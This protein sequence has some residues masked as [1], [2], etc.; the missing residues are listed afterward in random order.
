MLV[1][2]SHDTLTCRGDFSEIAR[3]AQLPLKCQKLV[4]NICTVNI[5]L[6]QNVLLQ[7]QLEDKFLIRSVH[8]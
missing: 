1:N 6:T 2:A 3:E 5:R 7:I 8:S 4:G